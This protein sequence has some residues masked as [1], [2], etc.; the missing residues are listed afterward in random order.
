[1]KK[2]C[3]AGLHEHVYRKGV[4]ETQRNRKRDEEYPGRG[5]TVAATCLV[6]GVLI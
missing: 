3:S 1:M 4:G 6:Q 5:P 2:G